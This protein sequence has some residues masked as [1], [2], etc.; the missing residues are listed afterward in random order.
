[1]RDRWVLFWHI[2]G[3]TAFF[4]L[5]ALLIGALVSPRNTRVPTVTGMP[6]GAAQTVLA[7]ASLRVGNVSRVCSDTVAAGLVISQDPPANARVRRNST[8]DL[9]VSTGPCTVAVPD[10]TGLSRADAETVL[11]AAGLGVGPVT[12]LCSDTVAAGFV[13]GQSPAGGTR[14]QPGS[15]VL[16][17]VSSGPCPPVSIAVPNVTGTEQADAVAAILGVGL[18]VGNITEA[19][20]DTVPA[21]NVVSQSPEGGAMVQP[22]TGV[23]LVVSSGPCP[24]AVPDVTGM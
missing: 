3:F 19:C 8:V 24:V 20:S 22:G 23:D 17:Q 4:A 7:D 6:E 11:A 14:V 10:L 16:L 12:E 1:M 9:T 18:S 2:F 5:I 21:G 13:I 15:A